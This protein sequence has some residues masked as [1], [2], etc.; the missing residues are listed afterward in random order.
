[1]FFDA[2]VASFASVAV[3]EIGDKT[4]LLSLFLAA[5]FRSR[6]AIIAGILVATLLNHAASAWFGA[7]VAQFIP[8]GW[9][10]WLLG[11]SFIAVAL[12][13]LIPDKDD[14]EEVSVLKYGAF[15]ASCILFF[16]AEIGDKTQVATVLLAATYPETWQVILGTTI[17]ML[18]ANVPVVYA[19]SWLLERISLDWARRV[20][21]AIFMLLGVV[22]ILMY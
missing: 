22:T 4:Q 1:M 11:G 5:R 2:F 21:C 14:S 19:G 9:H 20:A 13:L 12:W 8:E 18:A 10:S 16:L 15:F 6:G 17:G 7:W 3:A